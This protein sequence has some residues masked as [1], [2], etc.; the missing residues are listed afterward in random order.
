MGTFWRD[1]ND[2]NNFTNFTNFSI[3]YLDFANLFSTKCSQY[4]LYTYITS[5]LKKYE[6]L[7]KYAL[8]SSDGIL[9]KLLYMYMDIHVR[10]TCKWP[11]NLI[12]IYV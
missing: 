6:S 1:G 3:N 2:G 11:D 8:H 12:T 4:K 5:K 9:D 7:Q 10:C